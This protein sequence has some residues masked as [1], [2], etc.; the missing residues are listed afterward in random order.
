MRKKEIRKLVNSNL[1]M[2]AIQSEHKFICT[3]CGN[4]STPDKDIFVKP[5][6]KNANFAWLPWNFYSSFYPY[7]ARPLFCSLEC[8]T[9][10]VYKNQKDILLY[11]ANNSITF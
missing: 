6:A 2:G 1:K 5:G 8:V 3:H 4:S 7:K 10:F 9:D 11:M